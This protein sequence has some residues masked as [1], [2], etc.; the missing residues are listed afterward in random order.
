MQTSVATV[1]TIYLQVDF[2]PYYERC[3]VYF[4]SIGYREGEVATRDGIR[5]TFLTDVKPDSAC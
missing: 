4:Q 1:S 2:G 5:G 3:K